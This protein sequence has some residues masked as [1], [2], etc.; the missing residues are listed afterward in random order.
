M[1]SRS[2]VGLSVVRVGSGERDQQD[3]VV[4]EG[5][6][7]VG[8]VTYEP[9]RRAWFWMMAGRKLRDGYEP[10]REAALRALARSYRRGCRRTGGSADAED[11]ACAWSC[12][13][14]PA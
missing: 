6:R 11:E 2:G 5:P 1:A 13:Q 10:T 9:G 4:Y 3:L 12:V 14:L 8:R 7:E